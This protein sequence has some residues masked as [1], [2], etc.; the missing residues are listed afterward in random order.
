M[1]RFS[2]KVKPRQE[3]FFSLRNPILFSMATSNDVEMKDAD[4]AV[5]ATANGSSQDVEMED[6]SAQP[7]A[8][9]PAQPLVVWPKCRL[10]ALLAASANTAN[11]RSVA[12]GN[13]PT[14]VANGSTGDAVVPNISGHSIGGIAGRPHCKVKIRRSRI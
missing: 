8:I 4:G 2:V 14:N 11:N 7:V 6:V 5:T 9:D 12:F 10:C 3:A 13:L 1:K